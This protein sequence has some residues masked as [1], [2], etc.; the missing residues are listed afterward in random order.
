MLRAGRVAAFLTLATG[1]N[2][3]IATLAP[4]YDPIYAYLLSI[5]V[6]AW[7]GSMLLGVMAA[8]AAVV[9]YDFMF[10]PAPAI[11]TA[12]AI[13]PFAVAIAVA[14]ATRLVRAP[15]MQR[16]ELPPSTPPAM[17]PA[18]DETPF[19]EYQAR[20]EIDDLERRLTAASAVAER[21][22]RL[23]AEAGAAT[24][25]RLAALQRELD[26]ARDQVLQ[27]VNRVANLRAEA[28]AAKRQKDEGK[29]DAD[30]ALVATRKELEQERKR[31]DREV[32]ARA[33]DAA[34][35][36]QN[37]ERAVAEA[38][39]RYQ[40]PLAEAKKRL[41]EAF[42]KIPQL[43]KEIAAERQHASDVTT[44]AKALEEAAR[45]ATAKADTATARIAKL[46]QHLETVRTE[47]T[48]ERRRADEATVKAKEL[49]QALRT[50]TARAETSDS[51]AGNVSVEMD[52]LRAELAA[53]RTR[54]EES[55]VRVKEL[56]NALDTAMAH[57]NTSASR[58]SAVAAELEA[59]RNN[60]EAERRRT[61]NASLKAREAEQ[62]LQAARARTEASESRGA[63]IAAEVESL[64]AELA[65]E[66]TRAERE[67]LLRE[68]LEVAGHEKLQT[69]VH[70]LSAKYDRAVSDARERIAA[71]EAELETTRNDARA[72]LERASD[73]I[74]AMQGELAT[75]RKSADEILGHREA[76]LRE[77]L[78]L[79]AQQKIQALAAEISAEMAKKYD[80]TVEEARE[81]IGRL[82]Q[83][84]D[85]ARTQAAKALEAATTRAELEKAQKE[86]EALEADR[87]LE[88]IVANLTKDYEESLGEAMVEKE[89]AKAEI[90]TLTKRVQEMQARLQDVDKIVDAA[91]RQVAEE[92]AARERLDVEWNAKL[93]RI[94]S[95]I[96]IDHEHD[97]GEALLEREGAKAEVRSLTGK[98]HA[99]QHKFDAE[100]QKWND[101]RARFAAVNPSR[102]LVLVVHSDANVRNN[103]K[104]VLEQSG[105]VVMTASDGLEGLRV[106]SSHKPAVVLAEAVMPKMNGRELVQLLK[107][108]SETAGVK[109]VLVGPT[110]A[111]DADRGTEF[112]PD[113]VL[114]STA[115]ANQLRSTLANLVPTRPS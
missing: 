112:R 3:A 90:R 27:Q 28:D 58:S 59:L 67:G 44:R 102:P 42:T 73:Q 113:E 19:V 96:A 9:I 97:M 16:R 60:L 100:R 101:E 1:I 54:G 43:E 30:K 39:A 91:R 64:R 94:V 23:R 76:I 22:S 14:V 107:S 38:T 82:H 62:A 75:A 36:S 7:L 57:A 95:N 10:A 72:T 37:I 45:E 86:R 34:A 77:Q 103:S 40:G 68:Q 32:K 61:E 78:E 33:E 24:R 2:G 53:E 8:I 29:A 85:A 84:L 109:I 49:E 47:V 21:E 20:A 88:R 31:A 48:S 81:V 5:A 13:V 65:A 4:R 70:E 69:V 46:M 55:A 56:E 17:L 66:R 93:Q 92:K 18:S 111:G 6:I 98:L 25:F 87:K 26:E 105:Y 63:D 80:V 35:A 41:E 104:N 106:A 71:L 15:I 115:D 51:L 52:S 50:A 11:P 12:S 83:E 114:G 99:L 108:R 79:A 74:A 110:I 89:G